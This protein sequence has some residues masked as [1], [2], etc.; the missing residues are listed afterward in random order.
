MMSQDQLFVDGLVVAPSPTRSVPMGP[1]VSIQYTISDNNLGSTSR[2]RLMKSLGT[3]ESPHQNKRRR[4]ISVAKSKHSNN[5]TH[6]S[7]GS[8]KTSV[9][10]S[11][12][13]ERVFIPY[14][15]LYT[16]EWSKKLLYST[17]T[18]W[19]DTELNFSNTRLPNPGH[20]SW[21]S[22]NQTRQLPSNSEKISWP[23]SPSSWPSTMEDGLQ[24]TGAKDGSEMRVRKIR[25]YPSATQATTLSEW[26]RATRWTYNKCVEYAREQDYIGLS[27]K[28]MRSKFVNSDALDSDDLQ[29]LKNVPYDVRD[30]GMRDVLKAIKAHRAKQSKNKNGFTLKFRSQFDSSQ[31]LTVLKKHWGRKS[32]VYASICSSPLL[33]SS[34]PLPSKLLCDTRITRS[35]LGHWF[36]CIHIPVIIST[37]SREESICSIDPG[38]RA[39]LTGFDPTRGCFWD[40]GNG[41][42]NRLY[43]LCSSL[44]SL[45]SRMKSARHRQRYNMKKASYRLRARIR[46]I[47]DEVH[48]KSVQW[49]TSQYTTIVIP[50]F[51]VSEMVIKNK[52]RIRSKTARA[53]LNWSHYR[54]RQRLV[55]KS[56]L[57]NTHVVVCDEVYTSK[58]C[59]G[60]GH[61]HS[62]S[63]KWYKCTQCGFQMDRDYNG[64]RN[65]LLRYLTLQNKR[66]G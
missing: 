27:M 57:T 46:N 34:E 41:D 31:C 54:F 42:V 43:R 13:N 62:T 64:A 33:K 49:L 50:K 28:T 12:T 59:G 17:R 20:N 15:N 58:T 6:P 63:S 55:H 19:P 35:R 25:I 2:K 14:W 44:D 39:F 23:S 47:V 60:C 1:D 5:D 18:D 36:I 4:A 48:K 21:F 16:K 53:M 52:R 10:G 51:G 24:S 3:V 9:Q 45:L 61:I 32:G 56:R 11:T 65:I 29:W 37:A 8:S 38:V 7:R 26:L 40:I 30:E 22:M 66:S